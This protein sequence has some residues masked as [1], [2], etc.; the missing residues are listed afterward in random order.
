VG[1]IIHRVNA[2]GIAGTVVM[3]MFNA[4]HQWVAQVHVGCG[5]IKLG[6]QYFGAIRIFAGFH[7]GKQAAG[8]LLRC[9][10]GIGWACP[11]R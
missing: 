7:I 4:V 3:G 6:T 8:F 1:K 9:G 2:P 11:V 10:C 5:K